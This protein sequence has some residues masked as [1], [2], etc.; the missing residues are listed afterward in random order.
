MWEGDC[1]IVAADKSKSHQEGSVIDKNVYCNPRNPSICPILWLAVHIFSYARGSDKRLFEGQNQNQHFSKVL[2]KLLDSLSEGEMP[3]SVEDIGT[4][5]FRKG[6]ATYLLNQVEGPSPVQVYL[7]CEWSL[8]QVKD[9][10][11]FSTRGGDKLTG[12]AATGL[13]SNHVDFTLLPPHFR[14][15][16]SDTIPY[17][18][19]V[20]NFNNYPATFRTAFPF[21][22]ASLAYHRQHLSDTLHAAHPLRNSRIW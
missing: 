17:S 3:T 2:N 1:L 7:R 13:P 21:L 8:G 22:I 11:I 5:S 4:H 9:Q 14:K 10:Y 12:R 15:D 16:F 19:L 6:V 18:E 20:A